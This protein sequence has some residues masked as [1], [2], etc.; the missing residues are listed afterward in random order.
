M[1]IGLGAGCAKIKHEIFYLFHDYQQIA[2]YPVVRYNY[3]LSG[4]QL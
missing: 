1:T 4:T 3:Y 2:S